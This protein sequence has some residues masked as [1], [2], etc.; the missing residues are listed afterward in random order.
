VVKDQIA[1][2]VGSYQSAR[3]LAGTFAAV[4]TLRPGRSI[5]EAR[6]AIDREVARIIR[7]GVTAEELE[8]IKQKRLA[9]FIYALDSIGG[10]G[11]VADR[12]NAYNIYLGDPGRVTSDFERYRDLTPDDL[13]RV[14]R[15]YLDTPGRVS[16]EVTGR[17]RATTAVPP[18]R[19]VKPVAPPPAAYRAPIPEAHRLRCGST[20]W[21]IPRPGLPIVAAAAA[22][23]G[24]ASTH[25]PGQAGLA[26]LTAEMLTEGTRGYDSLALA[27]AAEDLGTSLNSSS[28]W[29]GTHAG[30]TSLAPQ[31]RQSLELAVELLFR[32]TFPESEWGRIRAQALA[33]LRAQ[34]DQSESLAHRAW[35]RLLYPPE[36]P[37][38]AALDGTEATVSGLALDDLRA[39]HASAYRS[40]R[41][42]WVL[43]GDID[44]DR[45]L[46]ALD[47]LLGAEPFGAADP[48]PQPE[49]PAPAA[50]E[51]C[52][53]V[54][55][56]RP[57][58]TQAVV[59]LG[60]VGPPAL[61]PRLLAAGPL[62]PHPRRR[63]RLPAQLQA[64]RREGVHLRDP[65]PLRPPLARRLL[66]GLRLAPGRPDRGG[67]Q[68][69]PRRGGRAAGRAAPDPGRVR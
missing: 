2:D 4:C 58:A 10:F 1:Q 42:L 51:G 69:H 9:A 18:D 28:G 40:D 22:F 17:A 34:K 29:D 37:F 56:H 55:V 16:L 5:A 47:D 46:K 59:K 20:A 36:H 35:L 23:R 30:M 44:P 43:A 31:L 26:K 48:Q 27:Q 32:P 11:G 8:R 7:E 41:G 54:L 13:Q 68:G 53:V 21:V 50:P 3:E 14:A 39:F 19:A 6:D 15:Q 52:R 25:A 66:R 62:E 57:G 33:S 49:W 61:H 60:Q 64:P 65:E 24:G 67:A 45:A 12:L 63:L 38:S